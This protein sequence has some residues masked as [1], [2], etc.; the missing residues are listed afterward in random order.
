MKRISGWLCAVCFLLAAGVCG[1]RTIRETTYSYE[2]IWSAAVRFLRVD[3]GY[4]IIEMD[5]ETGYVMFEYPDG[6]RV[7]NGSVELV[8][9]DRNGAEVIQLGLRIQNMPT[10]VETVLMDKLVH[11]LRDEYGEAP[12]PRRRKATSEQRNDSKQSAT[13]DEPSETGSAPPDAEGSG[14][15]I[16]QP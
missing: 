5:K 12:T 8:N 3:N 9:Q 16:S 4:K 2:R 13:A 10:Y 7:V 14:N 1:A 6:G 15:D 11:K